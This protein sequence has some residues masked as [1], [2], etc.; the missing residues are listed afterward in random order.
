M[1]KFKEYTVS[2][3]LLSFVPTLQDRL[4][5]CLSTYWSGRNQC[6]RFFTKQTWFTTPKTYLTNKQT[7]I[8]DEI[9][10]SRT[11]NMH[12]QSLHYGHIDR[13]K[14]KSL[15]SKQCEVF[16]IFDNTILVLGCNGIEKRKEKLS[17]KLRTRTRRRK[18]MKCYWNMR[19]V[20]A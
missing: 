6:Y 2:M 7:N 8:E 1:P 12:E 4:N 16:D 3:F 10:I 14:N 19:F 20:Y 11:R 13:H 15:L 9:M 18:T 17:I 5:N